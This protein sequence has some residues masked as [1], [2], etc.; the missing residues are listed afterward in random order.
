MG[1]LVKSA[2]DNVDRPDRSEQGH[3][4]C[5]YSKCAGHRM[6][7]V[8]AGD[9]HIYNVSQLVCVTSAHTTHTFAVPTTYY[10]MKKPSTGPQKMKKKRFLF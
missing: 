2:W 3:G 4:S 5:V 10:H 6:H 7:T 9:M 8:V 1:R